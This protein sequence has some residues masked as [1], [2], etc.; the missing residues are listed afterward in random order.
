MRN[1]DPHFDYGSHTT[2]ASWFVTRWGQSI[3]MGWVLYSTKWVKHEPQK[4]HKTHTTT[5]MSGRR[6]TLQ[7]LAPPPLHG[8]GKVFSNHRAAAPLRVCAG[9]EPSGLRSP[10]SG[11]RRGVALAVELIDKIIRKIKYVVALRG[12]QTTSTTQQ[13]TKNMWAQRWK[14]GTRG[15]T[16]GELRGGTI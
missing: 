2:S 5:N 16:V 12:R 1:S 3:S 15:A 11:E 6:P 14:E 10:A 13:P 4:T 9:R 8:Q 7:R